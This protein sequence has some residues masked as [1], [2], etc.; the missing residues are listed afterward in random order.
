MTAKAA[1]EH[2]PAAA[3]HPNAFD[4]KRIERAL[5]TR[6]RYRYVTPSVAAVTGGYRIEA[7]CC[8]RNIDPGGGVIDIAL[9][10]YDED[11]RAWRLYQ[12]DHARAAWELA[13]TH[14]RLNDVLTQ[15]NEDPERRFWQ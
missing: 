3:A 11:A 2:G 10:L 9:M 8:S 5:R 13:S 4:L 12:K 1:F 6:A 15:V 14:A 7:P